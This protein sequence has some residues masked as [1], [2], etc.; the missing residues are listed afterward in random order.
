MRTTKHPSAFSALLPKYSRAVVASERLHLPPELFVPTLQQLLVPVA[1]GK[2]VGQ[3]G[4][5]HLAA[6]VSILFALALYH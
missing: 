5:L 3:A 1:T 6:V 4:S 2:S